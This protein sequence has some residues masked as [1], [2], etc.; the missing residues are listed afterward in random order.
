M[1]IKKAIDNG[2]RDNVSC[3]VIKLYKLFNFYWYIN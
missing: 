3:I 2:T 1:I